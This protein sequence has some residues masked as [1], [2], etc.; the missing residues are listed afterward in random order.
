[1][2]I[3][4]TGAS[5]QWYKDN[6]GETRSVIGENSELGYAIGTEEKED[7]LVTKY[8]QKTHCE[9]IE[10]SV[11]IP[12]YS[13]V[14]NTIEDLFPSNIY[15]EGEGIF[16]YQMTETEGVHTYGYF[17]DTKSIV[18]YSTSNIY[19]VPLL[20]IELSCV[21]RYKFKVHL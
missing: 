14:Q 8:V 6:I 11:D 21:L 4:I 20:L 1:M 5:D 10:P 17:N 2:R 15:V 12:F 7:H 18:E 16:K 19:V 13:R 9:I 3:R